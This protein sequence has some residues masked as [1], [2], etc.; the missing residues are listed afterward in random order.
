[1]DVFNFS[2]ANCQVHSLVGCFNS[3]DRSRPIS[4]SGW[5][6]R[7]Q[8]GRWRRERFGHVDWKIDWET[9]LENHTNRRSKTKRHDQ[10]NNTYRHPIETGDD[11]ITWKC[12]LSRK[13]FNIE[14]NMVRLCSRRVMMWGMTGRKSRQGQRVIDL[15]DVIPTTIEALNSLD[16]TPSSSHLRIDQGRIV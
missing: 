4:P 13:E 1:M 5:Q 11:W 15:R 9:K 16:P 3:R 12:Y 7:H 2:S 14:E 6:R 8:K 10:H